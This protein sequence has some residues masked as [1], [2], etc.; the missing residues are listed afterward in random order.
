MFLLGLIN[1]TEILHPLFH[2]DN[3]IDGDRIHVSRR[4]LRRGNCCDMDRGFRFRQSVKVECGFKIT[5]LTLTYLYEY[6]QV[7]IFGQSSITQS[8]LEKYDDQIYLHLNFEK[9]L[10][11]NESRHI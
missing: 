6:T 2:Y 3:N 7:M 1:N 4:N 10:S 8:Y 11:F 5:S 9:G